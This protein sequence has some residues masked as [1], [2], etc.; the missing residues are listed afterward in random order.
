MGVRRSPAVTAVMS[1]YPSAY[2][3][4]PS[5]RSVGGMPGSGSSYPSALS[6]DA[7]LSRDI[8]KEFSSLGASL[9]KHGLGG[10]GSSL[11]TSLRQDPLSGL[12]SSGSNQ[13]SSYK[14]ST[15]SST[16]TSSS[17]DGGIPHRESHQDSTYKSTRTGDSGI[18]HTSYAHNSSSFSTDKPYKNNVSSFSYNI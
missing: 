6:R 4:T 5:Y 17:A 9:D 1:R 10:L 11:S 14:S 3:H 16:T 12:G 7:G 18:P 13:S 8:D 2:G 15:Y